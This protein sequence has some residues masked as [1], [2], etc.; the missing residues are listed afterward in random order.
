LLQVN[1]IT[2]SNRQFRKVCIMKLESHFMKVSG[3]LQQDWPD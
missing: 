1:G 3:R 2:G